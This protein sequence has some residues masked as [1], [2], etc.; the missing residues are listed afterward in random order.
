MCLGGINP[1]T[2]FGIQQ[3]ISRLCIRK[4]QD[5]H[6]LMVVYQKPKPE[7]VPAFCTT[8]KQLELY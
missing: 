4:Q 6:K 2:F 7:H 3:A 5:K 1:V 8:E